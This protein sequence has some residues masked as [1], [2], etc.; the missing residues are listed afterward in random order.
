VEMTRILG[1]T[2]AQAGIK[3]VVRVW[4]PTAG[5]RPWKPETPQTMRMANREQWGAQ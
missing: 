2:G 4:Q 1:E 3:F 5:V